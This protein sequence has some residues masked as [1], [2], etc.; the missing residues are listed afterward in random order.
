[1]TD[2]N[3]ASEFQ[4]VSRGVKARDNDGIH[5]R[6]GIWHYK[7]KIAGRWREVSTRTSNYGE[8]RKKRRDALQAQD[9]GRLPTDQ[10]K[11]PFE[12]AAQAWLE[13]RTNR[14]S[15]STQTT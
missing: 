9:E 13:G 3:R 6:R 14:V 8:A 5:K 10:A 2:E 11:W 7:L 1:M 15:D 4:M 12:K